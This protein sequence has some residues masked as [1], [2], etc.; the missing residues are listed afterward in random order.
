[1]FTQYGMT[2]PENWQPNTITLGTI[3]ELTAEQREVVQ[4]RVLLLEQVQGL[5]APS[6]PEE[7]AKRAAVELR[8]MQLYA[9][10]ESFFAKDGA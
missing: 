2:V 8:I 9:Q 3:K 4:E 1:M 7:V 10:Y 6:T 5:D